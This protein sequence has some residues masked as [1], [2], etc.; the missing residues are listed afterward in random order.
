MAGL[1]GIVDRDE[2]NLRHFDLSRINALV[3]H[4]PWLKTVQF[5]APNFR[6]FLTLP[7]NLDSRNT[8]FEDEDK[9]IIIF[10]YIMRTALNQKSSPGLATA[11]E[12][13]EILKNRNESDLVNL[14]GSYSLLI[15]KKKE[16]NLTLTNDWLGSRKI[17]YWNSSNSLVFGSEYKVFLLHPDFQPRLDM[18]SIIQF[19][20]RNYL[21]QDNNLYRDVK[22]IPAATLFQFR[23]HHPLL[24]KK[25]N[26]F[27]TTQRY[28]LD[29][30]TLIEEY[31]QNIQDEVNA[32]LSSAK[33]VL[34]PLSAGL[35]SR[36]LLIL[37]KQHRSPIQLQTVN[38]GRKNSSESRGAKRI[39]QLAE[40]PLTHIPLEGNFISEFALR[41][42][43]LSELT[44]DCHATHWFPTMLTLQDQ[45]DSILSGYI[46]D[47]FAGSYLKYSEKIP[48]NFSDPA[49][50]AQYILTE[51]PGRMP[52]G[53]CRF[54]L[55]PSYH[56]LIEE[57]QNSAIQYQQSMPG[58]NAW[59][60]W[61]HYILFT[62]M[63]RFITY[64][65]DFNAN[66]GM[67]L[68]PY[69]HPANVSF[70]F[71]IAPGLLHERNFLKNFMIKKYRPFV[72]VMNTASFYP[73]AA[74]RRRQDQ[75]L[76]L[77]Q[78]AGHFIKRF[79]H[80]TNNYE[81]I[82]NLVYYPSI[83]KKSGHLFDSCVSN[84]ILLDFIEKKN[85]LQFRE[86]FFKKNEKLYWQWF[87][88]LSLDL[89]LRQFI[90]K[91]GIPSLN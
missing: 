69:I 79:F 31:D 52:V 47:V 13:S 30:N 50:Q 27:F 71:S 89:W 15:W 77:R 17:Y 16:R 73:L 46:G 40:V 81:K 33:K 53:T 42:M 11:A 60:R 20:R 65:L 48:K 2:K 76:F 58:E 43:W 5:S 66:M 62:Q 26:P 41:Q 23:E 7:S 39:A 80:L 61:T 49:S 55:K 87:E 34:I 38:H 22:L 4:F 78:N 63:R 83:L 36:L 21:L 91:E 59:Q 45:Y 1:F 37:A 10:G 51:Y 6:A 68:A 75:F 57:E 12:V 54:L 56:H 25:S 90:L 74:P 35:D 32:V 44:V 84:P 3:K 24:Q 64:I 82:Q 18:F 86:D 88:L 85:L 67:V 8:C 9:I 19:L 28:A 72:E 14:S 29:M 70:Y